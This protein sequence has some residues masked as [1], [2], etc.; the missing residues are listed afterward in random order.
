MFYAD[1]YIYMRTRLL[2]VDWPEGT[3]TG[4]RIDVR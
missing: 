3:V 1:R 2:H 4:P